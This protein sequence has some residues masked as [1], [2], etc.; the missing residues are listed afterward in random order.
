MYTG[1]IQKKKK[2]KKQKCLI[3][4][5]FDFFENLNHFINCINVLYKCG[6][7]FDLLSI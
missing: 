4:K 3:Q 2:M 7:L 1:H 6:N 5:C